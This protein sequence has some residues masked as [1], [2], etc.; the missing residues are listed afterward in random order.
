MVQEVDD[1]PHRFGRLINL[2]RSEVQEVTRS[3]EHKLRL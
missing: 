2:L 3:S 1:H